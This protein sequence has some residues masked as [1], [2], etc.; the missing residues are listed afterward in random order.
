MADTL[1]KKT[2]LHI[3]KVA[4][5]LLLVLVVLISF[6]ADASSEQFKA[7]SDIWS[8][9]I[10]LA[11]TQFSGIGIDILREIV[12]RTG[13]SVEIK[14][15]PNKRLRYMFE[16][17]RIDMLVLDS[18][19]W[20]DPKSRPTMVFTDEIMSVQEYIYFL[21]ENYLEIKHATDMRG[22]TVGIIRGYYYPLF[23]KYFDEKIVN[24]YEVD[25]EDHLIRLLSNRR[26][27]AIFMDSMAFRY[28]IINSQ[29][30]M[31]DFK[32][33]LQ[34]S[35]TSLGIKIR[36]EK[37]SALPRFNAA[38]ESMK[39]DGTIDRIIKKYTEQKQLI[40]Q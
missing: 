15:Y 11:D 6:P 7:G 25:S 22:R 30:E 2:Y 40:T 16:N 34:L 27:D 12:Q 19:F 28:V 31:K 33:G 24:K 39:R 32:R 26:V 17:N 29:Y 1:I 3:I 8:P 23:E 13:D 37:A 36:R 35:D 20:N 5:R 14:H 21:D 10:L 4:G 9:F 18:P 38:I